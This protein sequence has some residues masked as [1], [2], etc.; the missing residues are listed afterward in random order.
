VTSHTF[1]QKNHP[2]VN[3]F[4]IDK[5]SLYS[6]AALCEMPCGKPHV[7]IGRKIFDILKIKVNGTV[8]DANKE[9]FNDANEH[10]EKHKGVCINE[11]LV[12][13]YFHCEMKPPRNCNTPFLLSKTS[14]GRVVACLCQECAN[15]HNET[16]CDHP[17]NKRNLVGVW[18]TDEIVYSVL[19]LDYRIENVFEVIY[20]PRREALLKPFILI[21]ARRK[22]LASGLPPNLSENDTIIYVEKMNIDMGFTGEFRLQV[23]DFG[24]DPVPG[25]RKSL[26]DSLNGFIGMFGMKLPPILYQLIYDKTKL[27]KLHDSKNICGINPLSQEFLSVAYETDKITSSLPNRVTFSP[28]YAFIT[29]TARIMMAKDIQI[30][31]KIGKL[32]YT[33]TDSLYFTLPKECPFPFTMSEAFGNYKHEF[34]NK[35]IVSFIAK[36]ESSYSVTVLEPNGNTTEHLKMTGLSLTADQF[37]VTEFNDMV[38]RLLEGDN[39]SKTVVQPLEK[40]SG[41]VSNCSFTIKP[42]IYSKRVLSKVDD[43]TYDTKPYGYLY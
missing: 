4:A 10:I 12:L 15:I 2:N 14:D 36:N 39:I 43:C 37:T 11:K 38:S 34:G 13:G 32:Y 31:N 22:I 24:N 29:A 17:D 16:S 7:A 23:S 5:S 18:T 9:M 19:N 3:M 33:H 25:E 8:H 40:K 30:I 35:K 42:S 6:T 1:Q 21:L 28:I 26:K 20:W 41:D 27:F